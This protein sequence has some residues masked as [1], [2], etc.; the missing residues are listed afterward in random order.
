[1]EVGSEVVSCFWDRDIREKGGGVFSLI[2]KEDFIVSVSSEFEVH[3][4]IRTSKVI[5]RLTSCSGRL[6]VGIYD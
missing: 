3:G 1:L 6:D 4:S 2:V 5:R